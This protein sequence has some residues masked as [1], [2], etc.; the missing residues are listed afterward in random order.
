MHKS[1]MNSLEL[2]AVW[3]RIKGGEFLD[4]AHASLVDA[5]ARADLLVHENFVY[6]L[7]RTESAV[8]VDKIFKAN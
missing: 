1:K 3:G 7:D 8:T 2:R 4:D 5:R 6:F